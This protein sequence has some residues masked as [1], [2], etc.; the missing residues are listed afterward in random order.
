MS[1]AASA[2]TAAKRP[3]PNPQACQRLAE[4][5]LSLTLAAGA[6]GVEVLVR[7][8]TELEVKVR[9]GEPELIKEAGSR[10]L[11][12]RVLKDHR[13]AVTYTSDFTPAAMAR[14]AQETVELAALAEPD[15]TGDLP[16]REVGWGPTFQ[17]GCG[18]HTT[19]PGGG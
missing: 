8:G 5:M 1:A 19:R 3:L 10:A 18:V 4:Q 9:L 2:A 11:G 13:A 17:R 16:A 15:P 7:D 6:D 14:F 12:L